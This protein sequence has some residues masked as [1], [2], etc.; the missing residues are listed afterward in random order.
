MA[1]IRLVHIRNFRSIKKLDW[2]PNSGMNC[3]IGS[4]DAGKTTI[5]DAIDI[6]LGARRSFSFNDTDFHNIDVREPIKIR[7][8]FGGLSD[9]MKSFD[10]YGDFFL[11]YGIAD[12]K[13]LLE[14]EPRA[15]LETVLCLTL[16][17]ENDLEPQWTLVSKRAAEKQ[18]SRNIRWEDRQE[19]APL[20]IGNHSDWHLTWRRGALFQKLTDEAPD[21]SGALSDAARQA[22]DTFGT[23]ANE[24]LTDALQAVKESADSLGVKTSGSIKAFLDANRMSFGSGAIAL[25]NNDGVPLSALGTGSKRL[26]I[27]GLAK[28]AAMQSNIIL[29]DEVETGL[30]PHRTRRFLNELGAKD[31][32]EQAQVFATS[33]SP[34]VLREL[35]HEQLSILRRDPTT[36]NHVVLSPTKD[37]QSVLRTHSDSFLGK[38]IIICEG[39]SEIGFLRGFDQYAVDTGNYSFEAKGVVLV[40]GGGSPQLIKPAKE[41]VR[42]G[43]RTC[44]FMDSDKPLDSGEEQAFV[45]SDG[46]VFKWPK[47]WATEDAI[48]QNSSNVV[49]GQLVEYAVELNDESKISDQIKTASDNILDINIVRQKVADET[50]SS[51]EAKWLGV[52]AKNGKGWF[53]Q[54]AITPYQHIARNILA[55]NWEFLQKALTDTSGDLLNWCEADA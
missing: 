24:K 55:P 48:F 8:V 25:H 41:F 20:R 28:R 39:K 34:V 22:R 12:G 40:D 31:T 37:A 54:H 21:L 2:Y 3:L 42:L 18:L 53:K 19:V 36:G 43:Y 13:R 45:E 9:Q 1:E 50:L 14:T 44:I 16:T 30:E 4:G 47:S 51:E 5:L 27:A 29:V 7:I 46:I 38:S 15:D 6:C 11:G 32:E 10:A 49:V 33:H 35:S 23:T 26:L 17:I 52:A